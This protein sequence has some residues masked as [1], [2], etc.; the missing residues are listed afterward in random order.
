MFGART[1]TGI[2]GAGNTAPASGSCPQPQPTHTHRPGR[3]VV[4]WPHFV[5][6]SPWLLGSQADVSSSRKR[7]IWWWPMHAGGTRFVQRSPMLGTEPGAKGP[8]SAERTCE[9][10]SFTFWD[11]SEIGQDSSLDLIKS[12]HRSYKD[13]FKVFFKLY[14]T[15]R[16]LA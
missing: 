7:L 14:S 11:L 10:N 5:E 12:M 6:E 9:W 8:M 13:N 2:G 1:H 16:T 15:F 4:H 3:A